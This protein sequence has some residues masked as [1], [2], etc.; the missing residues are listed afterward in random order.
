MEE[1][2]TLLIALYHALSTMYLELQSTQ[3]DGLFPNIKRPSQL[4]FGG[5]AGIHGRVTMVDITDRAFMSRRI[6]GPGPIGRGWVTVDRNRQRFCKDRLSC[7]STRH[8][9]TPG[10][11][12]PLRLLYT[13]HIRA[14]LPQTCFSGFT[15][16]AVPCILRH[17]HW[18]FTGTSS[19][20]RLPLVSATA[21]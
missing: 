7:G 9:G 5:Q 11:N 12:A 2:F 18:A 21:H 6:T 15:R 8:N 16:V 3:R 14:A 10:S 17:Y 4:H 19:S 1:P 20:L 13:I